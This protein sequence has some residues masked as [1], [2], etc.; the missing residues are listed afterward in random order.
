MFSFCA[1]YYANKYMQRWDLCCPSAYKV[2]MEVSAPK[3]S[4]R[5]QPASS[6]GSGEAP[7]IFYYFSAKT[8]KVHE[9]TEIA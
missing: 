6:T 1:Y 2:S 8:T 3:P 4:F 9:G 7:K 5:T